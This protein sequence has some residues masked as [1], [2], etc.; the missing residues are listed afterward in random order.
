M[1]IFIKLLRHDRAATAIEY[2]LICALIA[3]AGVGAFRAFGGAAS[4]VWGN[5]QNAATNSM[6]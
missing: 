4:G 5:V 2:G 6:N 3:V 1:R